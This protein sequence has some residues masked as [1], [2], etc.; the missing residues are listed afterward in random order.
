MSLLLQIRGPCYFREEHLP[1][2][3]VLHRS[4]GDA[5]CE[6]GRSEGYAAADE[7]SLHAGP[8]LKIDLH[9]Y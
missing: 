1:V 3:N 2:R 5:S 7:C 8:R 6:S 9:P 4:A